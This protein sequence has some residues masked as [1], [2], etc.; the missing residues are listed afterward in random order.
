MIGRSF[1]IFWS[2]PRTKGP[3]NV[4]ISTANEVCITITVNTSF[5]IL[6]PFIFPFFLL[7]FRG[8]FIVCTG[9]VSI[10]IRVKDVY[11]PVINGSS[12]FLNPPN[13]AQRP[14]GNGAQRQ[15]Q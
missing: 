5:V 10:F 8:C 12:N 14:C 13:P 9:T 11:L 4:S 15:G 2:R 7:L 1:L 6:S 3:A